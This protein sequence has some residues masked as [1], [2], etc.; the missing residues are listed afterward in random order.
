MQSESQQNK[1]IP[2][3]P[4]DHVLIDHHE[5]KHNRTILFAVDQSSHTEYAMKWLKNNFLK[6]ETDLLVLVNVRTFPSLYNYGSPHGDFLT[7]AYQLDEEA[8]RASHSLLQKYG[9]ELKQSG[10]FVRAIA[11]RGDPRSELVRK[12]TELKA[13]TIVVSSRGLGAIKRTF[14]GST[15]DYV[16]HH[17][18]CP[19]LVV[20]QPGESDQ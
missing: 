12:S 11:I 18:T 20:K 15:S 13:D 3:D 10:Y 5:D 17:A 8:R 4:E 19:V 16:C 7:A 6:R 2:T 14:L 9:G 1:I